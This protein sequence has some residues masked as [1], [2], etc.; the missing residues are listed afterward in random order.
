MVRRSKPKHQLDA[1]TSSGLNSSEN[2][3]AAVFCASCG[4][5]GRELSLCL[6]HGHLV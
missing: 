5:A 6:A 4:L 1:G 3:C 2:D